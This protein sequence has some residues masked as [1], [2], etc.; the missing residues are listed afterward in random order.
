MV[1][2]FFGFLILLVVA[3]GFYLLYD[4]LFRPT[5]RPTR[6]AYLDA[7][8][9]LLDGKRE[10][11][12]A[13]LRQVVTEDPSNVDAYLRLG[14][15]LREYRKPDR[16]LQVHKDLTLRGGL[17]D[18]TKI[19]ILR[20]LALDY[21][22]LDDVDQAE[23]ALKELIHLRSDDH[24]AHVQLLKVHE[25]AQKWNGAYDVAVAVL[26]LEGNKSR[27]PLAVYKYRMGEDLLKRREFHKARILFKEAIG[28]DPKFVKAYLAVG[29]SYAEEKRFEDAVNIWNKLIDAVP[30]QGHQVIE[31]LKTTLFDLGRFGEIAGTCESIL[32]HSPSNMEARLTLAEFH[33]KKGD[34]GT[35]EAILTQLV[36]DFPRSLRGILALTRIYLEQGDKAKLDHLF[37]RL[38]KHEQRAQ[39]ASKDDVVDATLIGIQ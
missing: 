29:D 5:G 30:D 14:R 9:D 13:K 27:R 26:K 18:E 15:I 7:L 2:Y 17:S 12:F 36:D 20:E 37:R 34:L 25:K 35:A 22:A 31:R 24:W 32:R 38:E 8:K 23:A 16:A 4:R 3:I 21:I 33:Q 39:Q 19:T 10:S 1:E 6:F 28:L 11:A